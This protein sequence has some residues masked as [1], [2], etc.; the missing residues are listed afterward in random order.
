MTVRTTTKTKRS[1]LTVATRARNQGFNASIFKK[2]GGRY[3][4]SV[5]K[6]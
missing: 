6:K 5:T 2:K 4:V 3:G 1:A